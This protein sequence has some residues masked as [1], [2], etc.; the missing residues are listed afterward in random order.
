MITDAT[1]N[2]LCW[3]AGLKDGGHNLS[4]SIADCTYSGEDAMSRLEAAVVDCLNALDVLNREIN[5][6]IPSATSIRAAVL[7]RNVVYAATEITRMLRESGRGARSMRYKKF[8]D[9]AV[10]KIEVGWSAVLA[11]DIDNILEHVVHEE[12]AHS[13]Q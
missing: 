5:G 13:R 4:S 8:L 1:V 7:P 12:A 10:R 11:G 3:H 6:P 2:W 9:E